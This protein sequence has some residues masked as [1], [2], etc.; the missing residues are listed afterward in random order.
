M[1]TRLCETTV[2]CMA[3]VRHYLKYKMQ[4]ESVGELFCEV[5]VQLVR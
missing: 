2:G 4:R 5:R 3:F 1:I